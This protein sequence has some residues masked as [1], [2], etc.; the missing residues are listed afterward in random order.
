MA[1]DSPARPP[2]NCLWSCGARRLSSVSGNR[3]TGIPATLQTTHSVDVGGTVTGTVDENRDMDAF[4]VTLVAG[5]TYEFELIGRSG[6]GEDTLPDPVIVGLLDPSGGMLP[7][8]RDDDSGM[9]T[10]SRMR[11]VA[12]ESGTHAIVVTGDRGPLPFG[13]S[14]RPVPIRCRSSR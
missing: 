14:A 12:Q 1:P 6:F 8:T 11:F 9:G 2:P 10:N 3:R 13:Q 4:R 7:G 5:T